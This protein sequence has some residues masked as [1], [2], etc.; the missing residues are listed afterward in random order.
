MAQKAEATTC[1]IAT[2]TNSARASQACLASHPAHLLDIIQRVQ[3]LA[4]GAMY[5]S[6]RVEHN[7]LRATCEEECCWFP[8]M[9]R[10]VSC[11]KDKVQWEQIGRAHV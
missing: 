5:E 11:G 8:K 7:L 4:K 9:R 3:L 1:S 10:S 6:P 2:Q